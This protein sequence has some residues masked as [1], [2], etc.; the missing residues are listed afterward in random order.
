MTMNQ[1][2]PFKEIEL[3]NKL[4]V[5]GILK[6]GYDLD[7]KNYGAKFL[8]EASIKGATLYGIGFRHRHLQDVEPNRVYSGVGLAFKDP[9]GVAYGEIFEV[10]DGLWNWV[11]TI[12]QNGLCYTRKIVQCEL[13]NMPAYAMYDTDAERIVNAWCYEYTYP[14]FGFEHP[15]EGGKF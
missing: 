12:E 7:L 6:R 13:V 11:D 10:P 5:Y 15:I 1:Y 2:I 14:G 8:S 3:N 4:F 9:A